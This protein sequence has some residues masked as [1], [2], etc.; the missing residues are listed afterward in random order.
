MLGVGAGWCDHQGGNSS[1]VGQF[2]PFPP[3]LRLRQALHKREVRVKPDAA[4]C[5]SVPNPQTCLGVDVALGWD[6]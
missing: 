3:R 1:G 4:K 6:L 2:E 5:D